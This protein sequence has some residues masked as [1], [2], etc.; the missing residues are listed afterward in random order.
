MLRVAYLKMIYALAGMSWFAYWTFYL[1]QAPD[2]NPNPLAFVVC[3]L[4]FAATPA[5]G[6]VLL[7][8][9][10]PWIGRRLR[11]RLNPA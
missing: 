6:Y 4:V 11:H 5:L 3:L 10:F 8:K 2:R 9:I 7:F 1:L